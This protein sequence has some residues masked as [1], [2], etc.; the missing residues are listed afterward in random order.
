MK[1]LIVNSKEIIVVNKEDPGTRVIN[2][3]TLEECPWCHTEPRVII[4]PL[5]NGMH[6]YHG[7]FEYY[8]SC[9]NA[10][11]KI[12]PKTKKYNDIY[13][14]TEEDCIIKATSDWNNR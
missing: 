11:C 9:D 10:H 13:N 6:G 3:G 5:W 7:H 1:H 12:Q 8:V 2:I 14:M 4:N